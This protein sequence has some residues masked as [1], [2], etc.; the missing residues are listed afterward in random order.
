MFQNDD[1][2]R[3][4]MSH[5]Y[6]DFVEYLSAVQELDNDLIPNGVDVTEE[7]GLARSF[8]R[9]ATTRAQNASV[10]DADI[11]WINRWGTA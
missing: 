8:Q 6:Q 11:N 3:R 1:G 9:G 10:S 4:S 5:F 2:S 7:Y